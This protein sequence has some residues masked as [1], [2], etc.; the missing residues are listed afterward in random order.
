V[1][2]Q[3]HAQAAFYCGKD[4]VTFVQEAGW[5]PGPV[6][7]GAEDFDPTGIRSPDR[8]ARSQ[9]LYRLIYPANR[10]WCA[11]HFVQMGM[12]YFKPQQKYVTCPCKSHTYIHQSVSQSLKREHWNYCHHLFQCR[13][14]STLGHFSTQFPTQH[15]QYMLLTCAD[16]LLCLQLH[17]AGTSFNLRIAVFLM[18]H[19]YT[20]ILR[21]RLYLEEFVPNQ[22]R[23]GWRW[24]HFA[25][26]VIVSIRGQDTQH[27]ATLQYN[28]S[29]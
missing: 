29:H 21:Y 6:C 7:T 10:L 2:D 22:S 15:T 25:G 20:L 14:F 28:M 17:T 5:G 16:G 3:R 1:R 23:Q 12:K 27:H 8:P 13:S 26:S 11:M 19:P 18:N 24:H 4:P 9:S